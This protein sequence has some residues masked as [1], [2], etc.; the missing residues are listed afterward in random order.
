MLDVQFLTFVEGHVELMPQAVHD[1]E[2]HRETDAENPGEIP[3]DP[4]PQ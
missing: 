1:T 2:E 4:D 3:H